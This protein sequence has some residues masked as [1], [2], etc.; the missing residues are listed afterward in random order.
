MT[1]RQGGT[2][3]DTAT[4]AQE[5]EG[6]MVVIKQV[7]AMV[8]ENCGEF[9]LSDDSSAKILTLAEEAVHRGAEVE[10]LRFVA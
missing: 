3:P 6:S 1:C 7:P 5:R 10:I 2:R 4:V 9:Y 8:C